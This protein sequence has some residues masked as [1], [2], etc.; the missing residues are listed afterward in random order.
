[1]LLETEDRY[2]NRKLEKKRGKKKKQ[3]AKGVMSPYSFV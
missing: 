3:L 2:I 1:M